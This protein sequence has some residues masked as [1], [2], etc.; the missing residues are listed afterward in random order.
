M[1]EHYDRYGRDKGS[2][3]SWRAWIEINALTLSS[4]GLEVALLMESV[5]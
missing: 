4:T 5:D 2:L 3:S 1:Q